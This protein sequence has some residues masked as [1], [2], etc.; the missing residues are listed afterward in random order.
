MQLADRV[1]V[2]LEAPTQ[3][4]LSALAPK[5]DFMG[6]LLKMLQWAEALRREHPY[7]KLA[8][9]VTQFVVGAVGDTDLELLSLSSR[10]Y[11]Q[12]GLTRAYYSGFSPV[13]QT[14]LEGVPPADPLREH[15]LYQASFL[16]RDYGWKVEDLPFLSGGNMLLE[17]DPKRAWAE[18]HLR[19]AP[20]EIMTASREQLLRVP[21][22]GPVG[23]D[24]IL[25]ARLRG[26]LTEL[27]HLRK[28]NIHAPEQA[29]PYILLD[30]HRPAT[31]MILIS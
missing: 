9:T 21:G 31:Q 3:E 27:V 5:K 8:R 4:R 29:A 22:I 1:S 7:E 12:M 17:M 26:R 10:L 24:A 13:V 18:L 14:P 25:R 30:G 11:Q 15:R 23:A 19:S 16:L 6:E 28:L 20:V 2:N